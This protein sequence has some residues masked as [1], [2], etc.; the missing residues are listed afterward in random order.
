MDLLDVGDHLYPLAKERGP[1]EL[2]S[3]GIQPSATP[4]SI[5]LS[6]IYPTPTVSQPLLWLL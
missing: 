2:S 5:I 1:W 4:T 3:F 6:S